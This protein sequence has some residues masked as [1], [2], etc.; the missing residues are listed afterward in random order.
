M[1]GLKLLINQL[2]LYGNQCIV[3]V[4]KNE[5]GSLSAL[6]FFVCCVC[7]LPEDKFLCHFTFS[8]KLAF[9]KLQLMRVRV[10]GEAYMREDLLD[11]PLLQTNIEG[12][13]KQ[14]FTNNCCTCFKKL[15]DLIWSR[16]SDRF[17]WSG[18]QHPCLVCW[19]QH[20]QALSWTISGLPCGK[21]KCTLS[22]SIQC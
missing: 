1:D 19:F 11:R 6:P 16:M 7:I 12:S 14:K 18:L 10:S 20:I 15:R 22:V 8:I 4:N 21:I 5:L 2:L 9:P 13:L 3:V 17:C